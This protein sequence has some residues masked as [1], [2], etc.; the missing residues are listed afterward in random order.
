MMKKVDYIIAVEGD[1]H[2]HKTLLSLL[3]G[4]EKVYQYLFQQ[5]YLRSDSGNSVAFDFVGL[6]TF[7]N[8]VV[9][10]LPKYYKNHS[11]S[12]DIIITDFS[13]II[14]VLKKVGHSD[15]IPD[16]KNISNN[17]NINLSELVFADRFL[18][19]YLDY[20]LFNKNKVSVLLNV[21]GEVD[22]AQTVSNL[23]PIF[24]NG[25]P[26]Y[27]DIY[28]HSV[29]TE[30]F[31][32]I[33]ELHKWT[34]KYCLSKFGR[35]LDYNFLFTDDCI[36]DISALGSV[37]FILN[38][39]RKELSITYTDREILLIRRLMSFI[40]NLK[41]DHSGNFSLFGTGYFHV[42]WEKACSAVFS[43]K[44]SQFLSIIPSPHWHNFQGNYAIK[45]TLRPDIISILEEDDGKFFVFDAKYY[46]VAYLNNPGFTVSG[47][48]GIGDVGKQFL[49][50]IAFMDLQY[51]AKYNCFLFP[52]LL[53]DFFEVFGFVTFPIFNN[54]SIYNIYLSPHHVFKGFLNNKSIGQQSLNVI[55]DKLDEI[56]E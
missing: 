52:K 51:K 11:F 5:N 24:S 49:Y 56:K 46:N 47:N 12:E 50:D 26:I 55:A 21:E 45:D 31:N 43:N 30:E 40:D 35:I 48:P 9:C 14:K 20:G 8:A 29:I 6:I 19:D 28:V 1:Y 3:Q 10:I 42:I 39:L 22:W 15:S 37:E 13:S 23:D 27:N 2:S 16:S 7:D 18:R 4:N 34:I 44:I 36:S 38:V 41:N 17:E 33:T 54:S 53:E 32:L 25:R